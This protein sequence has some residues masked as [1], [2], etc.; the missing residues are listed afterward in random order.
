LDILLFGV[1]RVLR[2][3]EKSAQRM[4]IVKSPVGNISGETAQA[5]SERVLRRSAWI[6]QQRRN[7]GRTADE[8]RR[9]QATGSDA[10]C[11][12]TG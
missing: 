6:A 3:F 7:M 9:D 4:E 10:I 12:A 11:V 1:G 8:L 2:I 5:L